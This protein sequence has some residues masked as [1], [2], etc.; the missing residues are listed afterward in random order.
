MLFG[1]KS[2][3]NTVNMVDDT[4]QAFDD[5]KQETEGVPVQKE[6]ESTPAAGEKRDGTFCLHYKEDGVFLELV[7]PRNGG[8]PVDKGALSEYLRRKQINGA[9]DVNLNL[10]LDDP[11]G[12][13]EKIAAAQEENFFGEEISVEITEDAM[14]VY[15]TLIPGEEGGAALTAEEIGDILILKYK[16]KYGVEEEALKQLC[17]ERV[18]HE[19]KLVAKGTR[20]INGEN[21]TME[22][23]VETDNHRKDTVEDESGKI[24]FR[25]ISQF[26]KIE[27]QQVLATRVF[28]TLGQD[29][30]DVYG[31][32]LIALKGKEADFPSPGKNVKFSSDKTQLISQIQ[33][34]A[35]Y[36]FGKISVLPH[37]KIDG[38]VDLTVGNVEFDGDVMVSGNVKAGFSVKATGN[39]TVQGLVEAAVLE[40]G[41]NIVI[42]NGI[43]GSDKGKVTAQNNVTALYIERMEVEAGG[44]VEAGAILNSHVLS[45][46]AVKVTIGKGTLAGGIVSAG[47]YVVAKVIGMDA[48]TPTRIEVGLL[49]RKRQQLKKLEQELAELSGKIE[50]LELALST[51]KRM[52]QDSGKVRLEAVIKLSQMKKEFDSKQE[53]KQEL[54]QSILGNGREG[55]VHVLD[56]IYS[57]VKIQM[58]S[59]MLTVPYENSFV[60]YHKEEKEIKADTCRF[61]ER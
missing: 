27:A 42:R 29:G 51:Q 40:S 15:V 33:G 28:A 14:E 53:Q 26:D 8:N 7:P 44:D 31:K 6:Q 10:L 37:V 21:G 46:G 1:K 48:G 61:S 34:K 12:V 13:F 32:R 49:P 50:R 11:A 60:T 52:G 9:K 56:T 36:D 3:E 30:T 57:G 39:I 2:N 43:K 18:Y 38:D 5:L 23:H 35:Y 17:E 41:G 58:G 47:T 16:I 24:D 19:K 45:E 25:S 59:D 4:A 22:I 54:S 20:P 55:K